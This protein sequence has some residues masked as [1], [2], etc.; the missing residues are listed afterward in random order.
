MP[1]V[2][3]L[4]AWRVLPVLALLVA[5]AHGS[6]DE[7]TSEAEQ[8]STL[9]QRT[10]GGR[11]A[12]ACFEQA[13]RLRVGDGVTKDEARAATLHEL[14]CNGDERRA[15]VALGVLK[16]EGRSVAKDE[17]EAARLYARGCEQGLPEG[18]GHLALLY[19]EG[20]GV[21]KDLAQAVRFYERGCAGDD[22]LSCNNLG[23]LKLMGGFG[24][25]QDVAAGMGMLVQA[26]NRNVGVACLTVAREFDQGVRTRKDARLASS[27]FRT[28]CG[29]GEKEACAATSAAVAAKPEPTPAVTPEEGAKLE[30]IRAMCETGVGL[31]MACY[32]MGAAYEKGAS[33]A[34]NPGRATMYYQRACDHDVPEAC[35]DV[36]RMLG[37]T[38]DGAKT[39]GPKQ[40][41]LESLQLDMT[42]V[43]P[44]K[45]KQ[46]VLESLRL[47]AGKVAANAKPT[48]NA[49]PAPRASVD[50]WRDECQDG[51]GEGDA[52]ARLGEVLLEGS[53]GLQV[54]VKKGMQLLEDACLKRTASAC[55]LLGA[56]MVSGNDALKVAP[57]PLV[58]LVFLETGCEARDGGRACDLLG[59]ARLDTTRQYASVGKGVQAWRNGCF[60]HEDMNSCV[61]LLVITKKLADSGPE[62]VSS[63][64]RR[65]IPS[66]QAQACKTRVKDECTALGLP[67][68]KDVVRVRHLKEACDAGDPDACGELAQAYQQGREIDW[69]RA[70][71]IPVAEQGCDGGSGAACVQLAKY[72][73]GVRGGAPLNLEA[74]LARAG[75]ACSLK[76][77]TGCSLKARFLEEFGKL[78]ADAPQ[79]REARYLACLYLPESRRSGPCAK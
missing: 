73:R 29:M 23:V 65:S 59:R 2:K 70:E 66:I 39:E 52:C 74:M 28:A 34:V 15:C 48:A 58:G 46:S 11:T 57:A 31:G 19:G 79:V 7:T 71:E 75:Q 4:F 40:S 33:V 44:E 60:T 27:Y 78:T 45:P 55:A 17:A 54:D 3:L 76:D 22:G 43:A 8:L 68:P 38:A 36:R 49:K 5:C 13:E 61:L 25:A 12:Q 6:S 24:V 41:V 21:A 20:R 10:C 37:L 69:D 26:C 64:A 77:S 35:G 62:A 16:E 56:L 9:Y 50:R 47:D 63:D 30:K 42:K 32:V 72:Y 51:K 18:C 67:M 14:S 1:S 53:A